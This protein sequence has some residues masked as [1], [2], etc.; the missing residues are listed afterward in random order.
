MEAETKMTLNQMLT[1]KWGDR[2]RAKAGSDELYVDSIAKGF[3]YN[4]GKWEH[5]LMI[6]AYKNSV[7]ANNTYTY[8]L[9]LPHEIEKVIE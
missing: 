2:I 1:L 5:A 6:R 7:F 9:F 3:F 8:S 4:D